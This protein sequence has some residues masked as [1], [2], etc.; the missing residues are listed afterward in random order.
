MRALLSCS[1]KSGLIEFAAGL[2]A[3]GYEL[4][5]TGGTKDLLAAAGLPVLAVADVTGFPEILD[6][7]VKTLHPN[8]HGGILARNADAD[9]QAQLARHGIAPISVVVINLYPFEQTVRSPDVTVEAAI[10]QIDIGGPALLRAAAKNH[11]SVTIVTDPADYVGTMEGLASSTIDRTARRKLAAK[12][13]A[14]VATYDSLVAAFLA[15]QAGEADFPAELPIGLRR[16]RT[17]RYGENPHQQ[18]AAYRRLHPGPAQA[19]IL[20][21]QQHHGTEL[22]F[23]NLLDA[24]AAWRALAIA[25]EPTVAIVKHAIPCGL[26]S[27]PEIGAAFAAA[28][29]GDPVSAFGGIVALN[30]PVSLALAQEL[31]QTRFDI[32]IAPH[33]APGALAHLRRRRSL[34]LLQLDPPGNGEP[35]A[36]AID[37]RVISGGMLVQ[38]ADT[39]ADS[40]EVGSVVTNRAPSRDELRD[41]AYA[42]H[43]VRSIKSNGIVLVKD[44]AVV[45]VG[46]GQ[47]NRLE[48]VA[49][50]AKKAGARA[51]GCALASDAFFPF[52]DGVETAASLGVTAI[53]Q[54]GG[55][56]RDDE[57]IA[58]A[59]AAGIAMICTGVRH[60]RH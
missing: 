59:N 55:S 17:L 52:A 58:A 28:L 1:D 16:E 7:R 35:A 38:T 22:S 45:G 51:T 31:S 23:N 56:V 34:R 44:R 4:V 11:E 30:R 37:L 8:I 27:R 50:A 43:A 40:P 29:A 47:P 48:S 2:S 10:E 41:L 42:W 12:A 53:V 39:I 24:D 57:V 13:F 26:A 15:D 60:F 6:G 54:P 3:L 14:H 19:G 33:F 9:H 18:A 5:S 49:I 46:S 20:D 21:A 32:I 36:E 25:A